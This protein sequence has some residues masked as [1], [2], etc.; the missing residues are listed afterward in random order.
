MELTPLHGNNWAQGYCGVQC[1][2]M[3]KKPKKNYDV[4][5]NVFSQLHES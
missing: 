2:C 5:L 1:H 4:T 3:E